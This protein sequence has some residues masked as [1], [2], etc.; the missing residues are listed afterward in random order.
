MKKKILITAFPSAGA[1]AW[2]EEKATVQAF[3]PR[4]GTALFF[5]SA[6]LA[7]GGPET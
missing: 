2:A 1:N 6:K 5:G 4:N 7:R 3:A